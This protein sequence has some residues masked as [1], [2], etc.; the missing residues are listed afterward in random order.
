LTPTSNIA[1]DLYQYEIG[2]NLIFP[3]RLIVD[4]IVLPN[5]LEEII[6]PPNEIATNR[7]FTAHLKRLYEN[8]LYLY[9]QLNIASNDIPNG[10]LYW[11]G[12]SAAES[13]SANEQKWNPGSIITTNYPYSDFGYPDI[14]SSHK[15]ITVKK[16]NNQDYISFI[17]SD[18]TFSVISSKADKSATLAVFAT[19]P[20]F[21]N[22]DKTYSKI[23]DIAISN[24]RYVY[25]SDSVNNSIYKY[26]I[27]GYTSDDATI[28]NKKF[29]VDLMGQQ[30]DL[31]NRTGFNEPTV[32]E[33][34]SNRLY[35][36]DSVNKCIKTYTADLTWVNT[37]ILDTDITI[38][39]IK[40]NDYHNAVFAIAEKN[41]FD[42][43][44]I[45]FDYDAKTILAEYD[46]DEKY[47]EILDGDTTKISA[48]R[49]GRI[50]YVLDSR[51]QIRG[52]RFSSQ[53]SNIFYIFSNYNIYKKF[54]TKPQATIG[55]WSISR[56]GIS[57]GYIW[58]TIDVDWDSLFVT[59]NTISGSGRENID[60]T[61]ISIIPREDN[62]DDIFVATKA[63][64]PEAFKILYCN[65]YTM[66][67]TALLSSNIDVYNTTRFGTLEDE[68]INAFTVNKELY[69]QSFNILALRNLLKGRFTGSYNIAGN[70]IYEQY[71]YITN[72]ELESIVLNNVE[73]LYVHENEHISTEVIN[74]CLKKLYSIQE[75]MLRLVETRIK[76]ITPTL[77][78]TGSN[79][80]RIE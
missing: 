45:V 12:V 66:Y 33:A 78:L 15:C 52:I 61:D 22:S 59:W 40:Y 17:V 55:K 10:Y 77:T 8:T 42:Y 73:N 14:D 23:E 69:K 16:T 11:I 74:R 46:L 41:N 34:N 3:D 1:V 58:N 53:D 38:I 72:E 62:L 49:G 31:K 51:E 37:F 79:I 9:S 70:L 18:T 44:L 30:G 48:N 7:I 54:L 21:L 76:N 5:N 32:I 2:N 80:L 13:L 57:W 4:D 27:S 36:F 75:S 56:A 64:N 71:D 25:I 68:Y 24:N 28:A 65:E 43:S 60:I 63:G 20:T 6:L 67:D 50:K 35:V 29:L 19:S 39:D 26:D 47:E